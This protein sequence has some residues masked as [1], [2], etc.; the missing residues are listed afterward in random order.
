ME[1]G[2]SS[3]VEYG[4]RGKNIPL[5][6]GYRKIK[7]LEEVIA[8]PTRR[9]WRVFKMVGS[10]TTVHQEPDVLQKALG[11]AVSA[12]Y[13]A[14]VKVKEHQKSLWCGFKIITTSYKEQIYLVYPPHSAYLFVTPIKGKDM[15]PIFIQSLCSVF[16]CNAIAE[17]QLYGRDVDTL[18]D[19][20]LQ[21]LSQGA[22]H[23]Y[24]LCTTVFDC[25]PLDNQSMVAKRR[26]AVI[27]QVLEEDRAR[28]KDSTLVGL[29]RNRVI[30]KSKKRKP[31]H[32][33]TTQEQ[34]TK[35]NNTDLDPDSTG[36]GLTASC[37]FAQVCLRA[38]NNMPFA[39]GRTQ[40]R[41]FSCYVRL[42]GADVMQGLEGLYKND[43][44]V[45]DKEIPAVLDMNNLLNK[46]LTQALSSK[47]NKP[48]KEESNKILWMKT[49]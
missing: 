48:D 3:A 20:A 42:E 41:D 34:G 5:P 33:F 47:R 37:K 14:K 24:R 17:L 44:V 11:E 35:R 12:F 13:E 26:R 38:T 25:N 27:E 21:K 10:N 9:R 19:L 40:V 30:E 18:K 28:E 43:L 2:S 6:A 46:H 49:V 23:S 36:S 29:E 8:K 45:P 7:S 1:V 31:E 32:R 16:D 4:G 22:F 15:E 39:D